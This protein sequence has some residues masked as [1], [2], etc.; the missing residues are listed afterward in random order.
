M[1]RVLTVLFSLGFSSVALAQG[2]GAVAGTVTDASGGVMPGVTLTLLSPGLIGSGQAA[3]S[4]GNG[5]YQFSRLVPGPYSVTAELRGFRTVVQNGINVNADRTSR[6]DFTLAISELAE[7]VT[8][9]GQSALLDTSSALKQ[10]VLSRETLDS[11]PVATDVWSIARLV[12]GVQQNVIDV[13]GRNMP[14]SGTMQLHG[15]IDREEGYWIDGLDVTSAQE[16]GVPF[17]IDT[18]AAS[19]VNFQAGRTLADTERGG[20]QIN[21]ITKTGTNTWSGA[22]FGVG[23]NSALESTNV[24]DPAIRAQLLAGVP[25]KA[26]AA[27]PNITV[28]SNTP[29]MWDTGFNF[30]GPIEKDRVWFFGSARAAGV[31]RKQVGS[32]NADG[33]QLLDDF[34]MQNLLGKVSWQLTRN[35]Q[36]HALFNWSRRVKAHQN[37][38]TT[39]Q[40]SDQ[41]ATAHNDA[42]VWLG[43][44]RYTH[45]L[46]SRLIWDAALMH[47]AGSN[48]KAPQPEVQ[49]GDI[50]RFDAVTNTISVA[51]GNYSLPTNTY[52]QVLQSSIG[53]ISGAHDLKA[54]WQLVRGVRNTNFIS[55]SNYPA[56]LR[57]IFRNGAPDSVNTY[58]TPTG[59]SWTNLNHALYVQDKWR[60]RPRLT[61]GLGLRVEHD[62]ERVN[63]GTSPLCQVETVFI[64]G[65]CFPAISG[66]PNLNMATPRLSAIYDLSGDGRTTVKL[67]A[68]RYIISQVGQSGL[69]NPLRLTNDTRSWTDANDD[70]IP[71][72][73]ELGPSTGFNLGTTN[74]LNPDLHV[75][76]TN[77]YSAEVEQQLGGGL[78]FSGAYT[79]RGR[80]QVI[81]ATNLAVPTSSYVPLTVTEVASGRRVT[82]YNQAPGLL[83]QFDIY[84]DNHAELNDGFHGVD[85]TVQKRLSNRWMM[86]GAL[87]LASSEG[88]INTEGGQNTADLNNPNFTFRRGP[89]PGT[90]GRNLKVAAVY[91][92]PKGFRVAASGVYIQGVPQRTIVRVSSN[93]VRLTQNNQNIDVEPFGAVHTADVKM[94]DFEITRRVTAGRLRIQPKMDVFNLFNA[95]VITQRVTQL[96]PSYGNALSFLGA[97]LIKFGATIDF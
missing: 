30:G 63:D 77:E 43:I 39:T 32:Y 52:K 72:L 93:T 2:V 15:S 96:G 70:L 87:S 64:K 45:V 56:G 71:Q 55:T 29:H 51:S 35:G 66:A 78:V 27:N 20:V 69:I 7:S 94:V 6:V 67:V 85:L 62:F 53:M 80:R 57:A 75:P 42:R 61:L 81:G 33:T 41:R 24:T 54:G 84:Y 28:G 40:F 44:Y 89:Q 46:S 1:L 65:Q 49:P 68:N 58:N 16:N 47:I 82:I 90:V 88:D 26:L 5:V 11:L 48:D 38:A 36:L 91:E 17:K 25:A 3:L 60:A 19:E 74:R 21:I 92:L 59:S 86:M 14:D 95:G 73:S 10:T 34:T 12:P 23:S 22:L 50:P 76:Y 83:G 18:F 13:G 31:D 8:V 9:S 37:G 97:R 79:Y 4:D